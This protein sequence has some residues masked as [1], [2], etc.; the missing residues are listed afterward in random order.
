MTKRQKM[1]TQA[2]MDRLDR[3][4]E[5]FDDL[6]TQAERVQ[7]ELEE[8]GKTD[9]NALAISDEKKAEIRAFI[10]SHRPDTGPMEYGA[11]EARELLNDIEEE[12]EEAAA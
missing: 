10:K 11:Y 7:S 6:H 3:V 8:L 9:I 1:A 2:V 5:Y 12:E 4:A